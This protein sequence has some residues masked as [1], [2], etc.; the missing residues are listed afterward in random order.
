MLKLRTKFFSG[1]TLAGIALAAFSSIGFQT[2]PPSTTIGKMN[3]L[4]GREGEITI[5]RFND[6][7]WLPVKLRMDILRGDQI[8]TASE[9]RCELKLTEG[10]VIRIGENSTFDLAQSTLSRSS[11]QFDANLSKGK[12]WANVTKSAFASNKFEVKSP[13][14]VCAIRGTI[15]RMDADSTTRVGVY[16]GKVDIG[17]TNALRQQLQQQFRP[18]APQ[19][20][21]GPTQV[22]GPFQ[23]SLEQW[24][25]IV[26]GFQLEVRSNGRYAKTPIDS[27]KEAQSDWVQWNK[28]RDLALQ[29]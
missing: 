26:Q 15:Y 4:L 16:H 5:R 6:T 7:R 17:P 1:L 24:V 14:A 21:Q 18:G 28:E 10:S 3:F 27:V 11:R 19:Q 13:T 12:I 9:S 25:Q 20:V 29:R 2:P 8:R 23:V 22:P